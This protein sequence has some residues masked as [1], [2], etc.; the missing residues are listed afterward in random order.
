[1][2]FD[3]LTVLDTIPSFMF[4]SSHRLGLE[5][6]NQ[7]TNALFGHWQDELLYGDY[8]SKLRGRFCS[9]FSFESH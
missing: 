5:M 8:V 9:Y 7:E 4:L 3:G 1:M 6:E 2:Y